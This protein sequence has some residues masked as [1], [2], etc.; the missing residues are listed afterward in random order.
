[1]RALRPLMAYLRRFCPL[2]QVTH[3]IRKTKIEFSY[4]VKSSIRNSMNMIAFSTLPRGMR[5]ATYLIEAYLCC[6]AATLGGTRLARYNR[7]NKAQTDQRKEEAKGQ[8]QMPPR[9]AMCQFHT[10]ISSQKGGWH[11]Q[12]H[13]QER[14]ISDGIHR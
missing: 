12:D 9:Q 8:F 3:A 7:I 13:P 5:S 6:I 10:Q 11:K 1:M 14:D 2:G 4:Q